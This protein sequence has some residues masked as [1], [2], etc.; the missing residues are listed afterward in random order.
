L[1]HQQ[2][3]SDYNDNDNDNDDDIDSDALSDMGDVMNDDMANLFSFGSEEVS[4]PKTTR[5]VLI[6]VRMRF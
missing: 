3:R 5:V 6:M 1:H 2:Q 4:S